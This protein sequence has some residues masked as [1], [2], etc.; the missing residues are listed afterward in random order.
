VK[1]EALG[2]DGCLGDDGIIGSG[3]GLSFLHQ[4][5]LD[6]RHAEPTIKHTADGIVGMDWMAPWPCRF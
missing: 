4:G 6:S 3:F 5:I 2:F 1:F